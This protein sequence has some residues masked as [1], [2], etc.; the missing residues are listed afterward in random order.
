[1]LRQVLR[2]LAFVL[3]LAVLGGAG[4]YALNSSDTTGGPPGTGPTRSATSEAPTVAPSPSPGLSVAPPESTGLPQEA[5]DSLADAVARALVTQGEQQAAEIVSF[6]G[7][8][9]GCGYRGFLA[10]PTIEGKPYLAD[11]SDPRS[12][13]WIR[14][15]A[16]AKG[17]SVAFGHY[18]QTWIVLAE[19]CP[20]G[21]TP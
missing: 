14:R 9:T 7:Q 12:Q 8:L 1:M 3:V 15:D 19:A 4:I 16:R 20:Q 6:T 2:A 21:A 11:L 5:F 10:G 18:K 17:L 13:R